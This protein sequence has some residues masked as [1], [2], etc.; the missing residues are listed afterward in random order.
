MAGILS[1]ARIDVK[2]PATEVWKA[3]TDVDMIQK[4]FFGSRVQT[5]WRP[6]SP[7]TWSGQWEGKAYEDKGKVLE[8]EPNRLLKVSHF[9]PLAGLPDRPENYHNLT[10]QLDQQGRATRVSLTQDNNKDEA[11]AERSTQNWRTMLEG[12]KK[13]VEEGSGA[14]SKR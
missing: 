5:T 6:G 12:L 14:G 2:A 11:E 13:V 10:F 9:S 7:I 8:V 3:L 4:Y 1:T